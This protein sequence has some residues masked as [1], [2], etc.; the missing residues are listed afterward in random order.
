MRVGR[1]AQQPAADQRTAGEVEG[2]SGI[3]VRVRARSASFGLASSARSV[4]GIE[5]SIRGAM[6]ISSPATP[7]EA[8]KASWRAITR[9]TAL[10]KAL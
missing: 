1:E 3:F 5:I 9:L 6:R 4:S 10:S 8:R 7:N 2:G